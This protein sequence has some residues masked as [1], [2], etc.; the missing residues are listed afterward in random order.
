[1]TK[2]FFAAA[3]LAAIAVAVTAGCSGSGAQEA[4]PV[5]TGP[6]SQQSTSTQ[7]SSTS[8]SGGTTSTSASSTP[9]CQDDVSTVKVVSQQG[10]TGTIMTVWRVTNTSSSACR[11]L[12]Y[13]GMDFHSSNGWL[14]VQV[15]RGGY[16]AIDQ[17]PS[18][19]VLDP[20][21]SLY[22][23]SFWGDAD[24]D[25]GPCKQFDRVKVTLPDNFKSAH[26]S[27]TGCVDP[28]LVRVGPVSA[29]KPA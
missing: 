27:S 22:F 3:A 11:S 21:E 2:T 12:G 15:H 4:G 8:S 24:T 29:S 7:G 16:P 20:G 28:G 10:A 17:T 23:A 13:P 19:V 26:V 5:P 6:G 25:Q 18:S 9:L 14:G 1:M